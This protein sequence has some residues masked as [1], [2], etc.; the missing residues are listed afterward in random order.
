MKSEIRNCLSVQDRTNLLSK[1]LNDL[2]FTT[3]T[4]SLSL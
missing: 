2:F 4:T 3:C 1:K